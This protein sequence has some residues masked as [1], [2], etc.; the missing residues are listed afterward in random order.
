MRRAPLMGMV[1]FVVALLGAVAV[2]AYAAGSHWDHR[3]AT[4]QVVDF[5]GPQSDG[6]STVVRVEPDRGRFFPFG[7]LFF[8]LLVFGLLWLFSGA[9]RGR[10]WHDRH[11]HD[12]PDSFEEWH[13]RQH[14]AGPEH[15]AGTES[16]A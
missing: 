7:F 9:S 13:R 1:L 8:P 2:T 6:G 16:G 4:V 10:R 14:Q 11:W 3:Q 15:P 12:G 5:P